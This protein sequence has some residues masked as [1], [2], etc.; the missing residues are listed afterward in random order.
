[1]Q[2]AARKLYLV[3]P[4]PVGLPAGRNV[5]IAAAGG[6]RRRDAIDSQRG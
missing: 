3:T 2:L 1:M 6:D 4:S 5:S